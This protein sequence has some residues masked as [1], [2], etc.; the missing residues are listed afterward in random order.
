[1]QNHKICH[2]D[3][4]LCSYSFHMLGPGPGSQAQ[5]FENHSKII[6]TNMNICDSASSYGCRIYF[7]HFTLISFSHFVVRDP[8]PGSNL[9][10]CFTL[11]VSGCATTNC[12]FLYWRGPSKSILTLFSRHGGASIFFGLALL[13]RKIEKAYE[14]VN[15]SLAFEYSCKIS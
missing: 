2:I 13:K 15:D 10:I 9:L 12:F 3:F 1:M 7:I 4:I 8:G 14:H 5:I 6:R 11:L